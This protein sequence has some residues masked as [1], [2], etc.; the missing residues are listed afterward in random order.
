MPLLMALK[1]MKRPYILYV[2]GDGNMLRRA[3]R[4]VKK[5][6]LK[7]KFYG[8][9]KREKI[10]QRMLT[11]HLGIATSYNFDTQG[12][13]L[14]EAEATGLPVFF[15]DPEMAE[16]VPAGSYVLAG[17]PDAVSMA[18]ALDSFKSEQIAKMS[19][20]ML[21]SRHEVT[22]VAQMKKLLTAYHEA[23]KAKR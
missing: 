9:Q 20:K 10:M 19:K 11:A 12:M 22:Q 6:G 7:V 23:Q 5:H 8:Y 16:V 18:I 2:Y 15:C 4:Y 3:K 13:I 14:V 21:K 1:E 17:A